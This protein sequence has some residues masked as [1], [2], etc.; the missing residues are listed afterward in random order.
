MKL[1]PSLPSD[2]PEAVSPT[3]SNPYSPPRVPPPTVS[4]P[5][6]RALFAMKNLEKS[7]YHAGKISAEPLYES[8]ATT[9]KGQAPGFLFEAV[10]A[11]PPGWQFNINISFPLSN[12]FD[13]LLNINL[14]GFPF[15]I[16]SSIFSTSSWSIRYSVRTPC[17]SS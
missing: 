4:S 5:R 1:A 16:P 12:L 3:K 6:Q 2:L 9:S 17:N 11:Q 8:S 14:L 10:P 13:L 7:A 15:N